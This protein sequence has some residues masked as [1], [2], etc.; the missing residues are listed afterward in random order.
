MI[1]KTQKNEEERGNSLA[2]GDF[3]LASTNLTMQE[4]IDCFL[5]LIKNKDIR[6]LFNL[7]KKDEPKISYID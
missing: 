7:N 5:S 3:C 2:I 1:P 4:L 6:E